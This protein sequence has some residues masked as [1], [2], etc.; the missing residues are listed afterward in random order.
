MVRRREIYWV[1]WNPARGSEQTG[2][3]PALVM[4]N[5]VGNR[6]SSTTIVAAVT[7]A[8]E[9]D[10]PVTVRLTSAESGLP[11]D[12][13]VNLSA[14]LTVDKDRL[15][16]LCGS[17]SEEKMSQVNNALKRSLGLT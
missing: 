13:T 8:L 3:G 14:I 2:T 11:R 4:Q 6:Y 1:D 12:S 17:L 15:M 16:K 9:M 7:T 5:D 10:Y